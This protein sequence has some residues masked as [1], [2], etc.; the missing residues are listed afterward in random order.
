MTELGNEKMTTE[1][2]AEIKNLVTDIKENMMS[3]KNCND[4]LY[5]IIQTLDGIGNYI[6]RLEQNEEPKS[7][8]FTVLQTNLL[9]V[10]NEI[11]RLNQSIDST[12]LAEFEPLVTKLTEKVNRL[13][14]IANNSGIDKQI[15]LNTSAQ[16]EQNIGTKLNE[17]AEV[18]YNQSNT[19]TNLIK[20]DIETL[21]E[22]LKDGIQYLE[23][24]F[25]TK[26][27]NSN[28]S[29]VSSISDDILL[30]STNIEKSNANLKKSVIDIFSKIQENI[31][32]LSFSKVAGVGGVNVEALQENLEMLKNGLYNLNVNTTQQYNKILETISEDPEVE[33]KEDTIKEEIHSK[34][35]ELLPFTK[36]SVK[37]IKDLICELKRNISYLQSGDEESDY[38]YCMQDIESDLAKIRIYLNE[39][40]QHINALA[41]NNNN[42]ELNNI[43]LTLDKI[44]QR[45]Q[46]DE[47]YE[48]TDNIK[49][50][51]EDI[52]SIS[53]R[54]NTLLLSSDKDTETLNT[55]LDKFQ[56]C[57]EEINSQLKSET[58]ARQ[59]N[60]IESALE[61]INKVLDDNKNYNELINQS[62]VMLAEW[63]DNAG[64]SLTNI[65]DRLGNGIDSI[66]IPETI[67]YTAKIDAL[68]QKILE[69]NAQIAQQQE[70][71]SSMDEKLA[72][73]LNQNQQIAS[74]EERLKQMDERMTTI[75]EFAAKN[76][77]SVVMDKMTNIDEKLEKLNNS[78]GKLTSYVDEE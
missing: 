71:I 75:L 30:L 18:L 68:E 48:V 31:N 40:G 76:D 14:I 10:R 12:N 23:K 35:N 70:Y 44:N 59:Y 9:E 29:N 26:V 72:V 67:D 15:L 51:Q 47:T 25:K 17:N 1:S 50:M 7:E 61:R 54:V 5:T 41:L 20:T 28:E 36:E 53:T 62:L 33:E 46:K 60:N 74:L 2:I 64:E 69:Q 8:E 27:E 43:Y 32:S 22:N 45:V 6:S 3:E 11:A 19:A 49:K 78:I 65:S 21:N 57:F 4:Q 13:D 52:L 63:V 77:A 16:L 34:V 24:I 56:N 73:I 58:N 66:Q 38:T 55:S 42:E 37:D 39:L